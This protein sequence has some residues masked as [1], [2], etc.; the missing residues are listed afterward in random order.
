[1]VRLQEVILFGQV[2]SLAVRIESLEA[3]R[4]VDE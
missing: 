2:D 1:M 3:G 4:C